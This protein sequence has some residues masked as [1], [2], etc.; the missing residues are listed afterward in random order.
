MIVSDALNYGVTY[1]CH[2]DDRNSFIK[3]ATGLITTVKSLLK[4]TQGLKILLR[5]NKSHPEIEIGK[6]WKFRCYDIWQNDTS[7]NEMS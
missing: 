2:Y 4:Q 6:P 7:Q 1:D 5:L 3:Q